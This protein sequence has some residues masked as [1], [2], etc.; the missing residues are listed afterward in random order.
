L[1]A[2]RDDVQRPRTLP[3]RGASIYGLILFH[4]LAQGGTGSADLGHPAGEVGAGRLRT[5]AVMR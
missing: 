4:E 1:R 2:G 3:D 5:E